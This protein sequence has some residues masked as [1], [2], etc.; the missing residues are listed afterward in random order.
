MRCDK[1][2]AVIS[3]RQCL[4]NQERM[5]GYSHLAKSHYYPGCKDCPTGAEARTGKLHDDDLKE[6]FDR[7]SA[8]LNPPVDTIGKKQE[9][10]ESPTKEEA[11]N[12]QEQVVKS[13][14]KKCC[15]CGKSKPLAEFGARQKSKDGHHSHCLECNRKHQLVSARRAKER[16]DAER[17]E[18][19]RIRTLVAEGGSE[20]PL[21]P[22][23]VVI[24]EAVAAE[25]KNPNQLTLDFSRY[26]EVLE[27]I[28][29]LAEWEERPVEVQARLM[30]RR[31]LRPGTTERMRAIRKG[32]RYQPM[33][34]D[35]QGNQF[36]DGEPESKQCA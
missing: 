20:L 17:A 18:L 28:K 4:S 32:D 5:A 9:R 16:R 12:E 3:V 29:H 36:I 33:F 6:L 30:L 14:S 21:A 13:T 7:L 24:Q 11:V 23:P 15:R 25:T 2:H 10:I 27:E 31:L 22:A 35:A 26:P 8:R 19:E 34:F 1:M